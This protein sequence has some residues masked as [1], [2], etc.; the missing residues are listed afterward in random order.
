VPWIDSSE[1]ESV[2]VSESSGS[3]AIVLRFCP[4]VAFLDVEGLQTLIGVDSAIVDLSHGDRGF[5]LEMIDFRVLLNVPASSHHQ[6]L[7]YILHLLLSKRHS[8]DFTTK[9]I[10]PADQHLMIVK[11]PQQCSKSR[12]V[13]GNKL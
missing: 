2:W 13:R 12:L 1:S 7:Q 4:R 11:L 10:L 3:L 8:K 9:G 6:L 5:K